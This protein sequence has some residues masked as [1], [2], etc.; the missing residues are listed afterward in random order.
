M[1]AF[2]RAC[3]VVAALLFSLS[4]LT[5]RE[6]AA[7]TGT[8]RVAPG[9]AALAFAAELPDAS[10][11]PVIP[12]RQARMRLFRLP[13]EIPERAVLD[14]VVPFLETDAERELTFEIA[15]TMA[16]ERF[17]IEL[18]LLDDRGQP[19]Y[20]AR[21]TV[22]AFTSGTPP[23]ATSLRLRYAGADTAV[24]RIAL[25]PRDTVLRVGDELLLRPLAFLRDGAVTSARFGFAVHGSSSIA[26]DAGGVLRATGVVAP[27]TAWVVA[28]TVTELADSIAVATIVP[29]RSIDLSPASGRML[30]GRTLTLDA[31]ARD[32]TGA[33]LVGRQPTWTS[34]D[35][36]I[37]T[38]SAG[39]VRGV[40]TGQARITA[41]LD[42]VSASALV[43]VLPD[44]VARVVPSADAVTLEIGQSV[45]LTAVA[46]DALDDPVAGVVPRWSIDDPKLA[47]ATTDASGQLTLAGRSSGAT[48]VHVRMDTV[49]AR[50]AVTV[51]RPPVTTVIVTRTATSFG[52]HGEEATFVA[53]IVD[54]LGAIVNASPNWHV[55]G[56]AVLI[57]TS[58]SS[59]RLLLQAGR[60]ATLTVTY[61]G[62]TASV[63]LVGA[64][65]PSQPSDA[66]H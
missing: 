34:S 7:P 43:S 11:E 2:R 44:G 60:S 9:T 48:T 13:G 29:A 49:D 54:P 3:R 58:G 16:N 31:S 33:P 5:C 65:P 63:S 40:A 23:E 45:T 47:D 15:V 66:P 55:S 35:V 59:A 42:G 27:G 62:A 30:D 41:T 37:A 10:G 18:T 53:T 46:F 32:S 64:T 39:V 19:A 26:V 1:R 8:G 4:G 24:A 14:T 36:A 50:I 61:G 22:I 56:A 12:I 57:E 51:R 52:A 25:A 17:G 28:R 6:A 20:V 38:V 21:D